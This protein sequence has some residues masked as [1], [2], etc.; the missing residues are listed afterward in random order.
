MHTVKPAVAA[1]IV[2]VDVFVQT[3]IVLVLV[4][5]I[6]PLLVI[7]VVAGIP[8]LPQKVGPLHAEE[9]ITNTTKNAK[10]IFFIVFLKFP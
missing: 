7:I 5:V 8:E 2:M 3:T 1:G 4:T 6:L 10:A 9:A